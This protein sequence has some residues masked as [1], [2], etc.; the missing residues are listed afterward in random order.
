MAF[1][2]RNPSQKPMINSKAKA[3]TLQ[4]GVGE[5]WRP[6]RGSRQ[7]GGQKTDPGVAID[8]FE[9]QRKGNVVY[10]V[11]IWYDKIICCRIF[12]T[13]WI[14]DHA[15][16]WPNI[17]ICK[18]H[19]LWYCVV[20]WRHLNGGLCLR[21]EHWPHFWWKFTHAPHAPCYTWS[22]L[23]VILTLLGLAHTG[24]LFS[25]LFCVDFSER[26]WIFFLSWEIIQ[27]L[28][29]NI[30]P[31][32]RPLEKI[33]KGDSYWKPPLLGAIPHHEVFCRFVPRMLTAGSGCDF[34]LREKYE[35]HY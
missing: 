13:I 4:H 5:M 1:V 19:V 15:F 32:D 34:L 24:R 26:S 33:G 11:G 17:R 8:R 14:D 30:A 3:L 25:Q 9:C 10:I 31:E 28:K 22:G 35:Y 23:G 16:R 2:G 29:L 12:F 21:I 18:W 6:T 27:S 20:W 7:N